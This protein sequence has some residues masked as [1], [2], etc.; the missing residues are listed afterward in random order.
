MTLLVSFKNP[1]FSLTEYLLVFKFEFYKKT[2]SISTSILHGFVLD[3]Q[4]L[5]ASDFFIVGVRLD[6]RAFHREIEHL[7]NVTQE[8]GSVY[9]HIH[10]Q[11]PAYTVGDVHQKKRSLI[12]HGMFFLQGNHI[13][14]EL[15]DQVFPCASKDYEIE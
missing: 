1:L 13:S 6:Q 3:V 15:V 8:K 12:F 14:A 9:N 7:A 2:D 11:E 4:G 10:E 5:V